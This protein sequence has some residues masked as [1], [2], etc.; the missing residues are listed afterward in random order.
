MEYLTP[1]SV[2]VNLGLISPPLVPAHNGPN[3]MLVVLQEKAVRDL[4]AYTRQL[5]LS[6]FLLVPIDRR[7]S[8]NVIFWFQI[9]SFNNG[10]EAQKLLEG[11]SD[12]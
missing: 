10:L 3:P 7:E 9:A 8:L 4:L 6:R 5:V 12:L 11:L 2:Y 1:V